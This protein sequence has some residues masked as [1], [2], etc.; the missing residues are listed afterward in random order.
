MG[1]SGSYFIGCIYAMI[2]MMGMKKT[3]MAI[4]MAIPFVLL[5]IPIADVTY[6]TVRRLK[7][8]ESIFK[9]TKI[10]STTDY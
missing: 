6:I 8:K 2:A 4:M 3:S 7:R 9:A 5:L 10:T 1:D